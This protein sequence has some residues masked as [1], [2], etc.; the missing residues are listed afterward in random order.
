[1]FTFFYEKAL[2]FV[3]FI[4]KFNKIFT[5]L[6]DYFFVREFLKMPKK[7]PEQ[8]ADEA[9]KKD[10]FKKRLC[11]AR[12]YFNLSSRD[13]I[14][15]S[16]RLGVTM[17]KTVVSQTFAG[18]YLP[19]SKRVALWAQILQVSPYW[20]MGRGPSDHVKEISNSTE[21]TEDV[22][23]LCDLYQ[24]MTYVQQQLVIEL[25]RQLTFADDPTNYSSTVDE[26]RTL[27]DS[28]KQYNQFIDNAVDDEVDDSKLD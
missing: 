6:Y 5:V 14:E 11:F 21:L 13:I 23:E 17:N 12:T 9:I 26:V 22:E 7:R 10:I 4:V 18:R 20:L 16:A 15:R 8:L 19:T 3:F 27:E 28:V 25:C 2:S 24:K 1:M